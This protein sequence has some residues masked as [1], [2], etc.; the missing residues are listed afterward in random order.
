MIGGRGK[1]LNQERQRGQCSDVERMCSSSLQDKFS[2]L[3][4]QDERK[5]TLMTMESEERGMASW[6]NTK[7]LHY[8]SG[9]MIHWLIL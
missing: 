4:G 3:H 2:T 9:F 6:L 5:L 7:K 1:R 8:T